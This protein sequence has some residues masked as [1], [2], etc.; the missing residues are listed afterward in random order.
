MFLRILIILS[1]TSG[2]AFAETE[3]NVKQNVDAAAGGNLVVDVGFGNVEI[4]PGNGDKVRV[5]AH[6]MIQMN[7]E[8]REKE[9][10]EQAPIVINKEGNTVTVRARRSDNRNWSWHGNVRMDAH[11][12]VH[13]PKNF[14]LELKTGGGK[15]AVA[16]IAG[17]LHAATSG[18]NLH[19]TKLHGPVDVKTSGGAIAINDCEGPLVVRTSGGSIRDIGGAGNLDARTSGGSIDV[20][21]FKGDTLVRTSGGELRLDNIGGKI[22]GET[23]GGSVQ[24]ALVSPIPGDVELSSSAGTIVLN[25][26][27]D[28]ACNIDA[29][30]SSGAVSSELQINANQKERESLRGT[31]NGGGRSVVLRANAGSVVLRPAPPK[32]A[33]H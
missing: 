28:A 13:V 27:T 5:E 19:L 10:F 9:F 23:N 6:R 1:L 33:M 29:R 20:R 32:T 4:A 30:A 21:D 24:A 22:S 15:I 25:V 11:Y 14:N 8:A 16:E 3:E 12:T 18:G 7:D 17:Q 26:P 2:F 31:M